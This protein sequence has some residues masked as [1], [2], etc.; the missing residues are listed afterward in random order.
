MQLVLLSTLATSLHETPATHSESK[1]NRN[2]A[3]VNKEKTPVIPENQQQFYLRFSSYYQMGR[4]IR[5]RW[6]KWWDINEDSFSLLPSI[7][8]TEDHLSAVQSSQ[9]LHSSNEHQEKLQRVFQTPQKIKTIVE[10]NTWGAFDHS[11][12]HFQCCLIPTTVH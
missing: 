4:W 3:T 1:N 9:C 6:G 10:A 2:T 5:E 11:Q 7:N 12:K 8:W